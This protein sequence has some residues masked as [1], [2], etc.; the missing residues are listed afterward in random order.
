MGMPFLLDTGIARHA[1]S[2][3]AETQQV[4]PAFDSAAETSFDKRQPASNIKPG[5]T[6]LCFRT[7]RLLAEEAPRR[8]VALTT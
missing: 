5:R 1:H 2:I 8:Q 7:P 6:W 4:W 3:R